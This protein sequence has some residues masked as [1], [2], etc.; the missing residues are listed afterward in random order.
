[1]GLQKPSLINALY[2]RVGY[3][4]LGRVRPHNVGLALWSAQSK[5]DPYGS[6][7]F[8]QA[9]IITNKGIFVKGF[10]VTFL[11]DFGVYSG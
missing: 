1:M 3:D 7:K 5:R 8:E 2:V 11:T 10:F 4:A 6:L 9:P